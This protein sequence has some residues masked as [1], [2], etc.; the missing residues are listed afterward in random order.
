MKNRRSRQHGFTLIE[1]LV[2]IAIIAILIALLLPAV[3]QTREAARKTQCRDHLKQI[4]LALHNYHDSHRVLPPGYLY[5][6]SADSPP[7]NAAGFGWAAMI[8]PYVDQ[9]N[10]YSRMNW[11]VPIYD[12]ANEVPR[13]HRLA[14][15]LCPTDSVSES[16]FVEMGPTPERY[17]M[18][19]YVSSFGTPDL[20][21]NQEQRLGA[22]SRNSRTRLAQMTDGT[23]NSLLVGERENG[24]FRRAGVH[25]VH[26][27][28]E[29]TWAGAV[30][31]YDD[32]E[33]D[34]G[35]M[36]MFQTGHTPNSLDSDDRDVCAPHVGYANFL[37]G[38]GSCR[39]IS[40]SIDFNL[41]QALGT[42]SSGEVIGQF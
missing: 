1:L 23:S 27:S 10:L 19:S 35:H 9:A 14:I 17:A 29:T 13:Q 11:N 24:P 3:Q 40:E 16:S 33:D 8:L 22:F 39:A 7:A 38:D 32:P 5:R 25:G 34:H 20:D 30:R 36:A 31:E 6:R 28:Y 37:L 42:I 12:A 2:V 15:Y 26:F 18:A 41:Y 21:E 4:G